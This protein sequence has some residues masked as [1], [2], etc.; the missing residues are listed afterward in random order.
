MN[1]G[2]WAV[3]PANIRYHTELTQT[4]KLL[5]AEVSA[6]AQADGYCWATDTYLAETLGCSVATVTRSLRKLRDLGFIRCEKTT[7]AKGT[8]RHIFCGVFAMKGGMVKNDDTV[9]DTLKNDDTPTVK[10]DDT[11]PSTQYNRN[12]KSKNI[13][14]RKEKNHS[15]EVEAAINSI[16]DSFSGE[17][18]ELRAK[19]EELCED[20]AEVQGYPVD[21]VRIANGIVNALKRYSGGDHAI[22]IYLL[23]KAI[24]G[25]WRLPYPL[26]SWEKEQRPWL[27]FEAA[28]TAQAVAEWRPGDED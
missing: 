13:R 6:L 15:P 28:S 5:Y 20:R 25:H 19:I 3:L 14:A 16:F 1:Q 10:N 27:D 18:M 23:A 17:D 11:P 7:N 12:I 21:T 8:E 22:M 26:R 2:Y 4:A 9:D 24:D